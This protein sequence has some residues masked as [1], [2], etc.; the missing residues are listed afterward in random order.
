MYFW[1]HI[2]PLSSFWGSETSF[3]TCEDLVKIKESV[4]LAVFGHFEAFFVTTYR[5]D[6]CEICRVKHFRC[7]FGVIF[8]L[9]R[10]LGGQKRRFVPVRT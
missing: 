2:L 7:T 6:V 5:E 8:C 9:F 10:H 3:C 4:I 1:G